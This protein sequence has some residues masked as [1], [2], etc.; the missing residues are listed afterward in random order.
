MQSTGVSNAMWIPP[1]QGDPPAQGSGFIPAPHEAIQSIFGTTKCYDLI[2]ASN[3]V[4]LVMF[5]AG[6]VV[7]VRNSP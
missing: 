2:G 1:S 4:Q 7:I 6:T 5:L 3:K